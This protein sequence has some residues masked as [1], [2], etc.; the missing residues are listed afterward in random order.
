M[1]VLNLQDKS[2][3]A[4]LENKEKVFLDTGVQKKKKFFLVL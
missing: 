4:P 3:G 2:F 1:E